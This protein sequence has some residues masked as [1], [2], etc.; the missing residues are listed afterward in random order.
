[1]G[2]KS[3]PNPKPGP[4]VIPCE[5]G[6]KNPATLLQGMNDLTLVCAKCGA[7]LRVKVVYDG[8]GKATMV[9]GTIEKVVAKRIELI[10]K[11][12]G[13]LPPFKVFLRD[14]IRKNLKTMTRR[15]MRPQ[16]SC[17]GALLHTPAD[18]LWY[19]W[20]VGDGREYFAKC[21]YG[22]PGQVRY[23]REPL[24]KDSQGVARYADDNALVYAPT[25]ELVTWR[26]QR[27]ILPQIFMP[28]D[29]ARTF[30]TLTEIRG[31]QVQDIS[32]EDA[33][34]EGV[35][36]GDPLHPFAVYDF[37]MLWDSINAKRGFGWNVNPW[38]WAI[39]FQKVECE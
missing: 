18:E 37:S 19:T 8:Y 27:D 1:M 39:T 20:P 17:Q 3:I 23:M 21:P 11:A 33:I 28:K 36:N 6:K 34:A 30:V 12:F 14:S 31:E 32:F 15:V 38:V 5:C 25:G 4:S 16:P 26:W 13:P 9:E 7:T 2:K 35:D 24:V 29:L 22:I 10:E